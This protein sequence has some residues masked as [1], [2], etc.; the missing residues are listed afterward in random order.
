MSE[1]TDPA[2]IHERTL[3]GGIHLRTFPREFPEG[4]Y[5]TGEI[6]EETFSREISGKL[7]GKVS[8]DFLNIFLNELFLGLCT[9]I[10]GIPEGTSPGGRYSTP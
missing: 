8:K 4:T 7:L 9:P 10:R 6:G 1:G 5:F 2:G 3:P